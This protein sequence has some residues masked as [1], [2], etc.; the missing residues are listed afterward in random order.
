GSGNRYD[1][2]YLARGSHFTGEIHGHEMEWS[3]RE[4]WIVNTLFSCL[5]TIG[6][7]HSFVPR[8]NPRFVST[9]ASEDRC[10]LNGLAMQGGRPRCVTS[11][12]ETDSPRG[13]RP[14][15]GVGGCLI[16]VP[17][18]EIVLRQLSMPHSPRIHQGRLWFLESGLGRLVVLDPQS[19]NKRTVA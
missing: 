18:R 1:S 6:G 19:G 13:W 8:W 15:K 7:S 9:L 10:H 5:C 14:D 2:C 17:S 12:G 3:G 16:D 4:L 11:L